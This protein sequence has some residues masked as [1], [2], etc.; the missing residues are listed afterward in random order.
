MPLLKPT[1]PSAMDGDEVLAED[2]AM[3]LPMIP[4]PPTWRR[5]CCSSLVSNGLPELRCLG[6]V[7]L[8]SSLQSAEGTVKSP[9]EKI[10]RFRSCCMQQDGDGVNR[11]WVATGLLWSV[12]LKNRS[13]PAKLL[14]SGPRAALVPSTTARAPWRLGS[15]KSLSLGR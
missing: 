9:V 10:V 15:S 3:R 14:G 6:M 11:T 5:S 7:K 8:S 2:T 1:T 13:W 4:S 12:A